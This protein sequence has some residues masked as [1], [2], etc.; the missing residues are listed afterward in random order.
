MATLFKNDKYMY[1]S[2]YLYWKYNEPVAEAYSAV[3]YNVH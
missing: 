3:V 2:T 1:M